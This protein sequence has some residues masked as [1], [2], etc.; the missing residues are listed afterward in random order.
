MGPAL[1]SWTE[2]SSRVPNLAVA[3]DG[4][5]I[6]TI[7]GVAQN[8]DLHPIQQAFWG[9]HGSVRILYDESGQLVT[10]SFKDYCAPSAAD[11]PKFEVDYVDTPSLTTP[12]GARGVGEG[13]GSPP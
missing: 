4:K 6:M 9:K 8:G 13:G 10:S 1:S 12:W 11:F 5:E 7:E 2:A 3:A